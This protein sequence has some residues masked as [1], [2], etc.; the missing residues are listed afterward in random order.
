MKSGARLALAGYDADRDGRISRTECKGTPPHTAMAGFVRQQG[1]KLD[2]DLDGFITE[3]EISDFLRRMFGREDRDGNGIL[4]SDE[5][6]GNE[7]RGNLPVQKKHGAGPA[8]DKARALV[9]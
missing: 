6:R 7:Y 5:L 9:L 8:T 1:E 4:D 3:E 2:A